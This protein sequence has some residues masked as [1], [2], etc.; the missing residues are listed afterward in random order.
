MTESE[1]LP[2]EKP[3][4]PSQI[5][6]PRSSSQESEEDAKSR[7]S[8]SSSKGGGRSF[9]FIDSSVDRRSSS[10]AVR[11]HVMRESHRTR[12]QLKGMQQASA[13][14]GQMSFLATSPSED[15]S[16][17]APTP[18]TS[19]SRRSSQGERRPSRQ[20]T[21][22]SES[23]RGSPNLTRLVSIAEEHCKVCS[24]RRTFIS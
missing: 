5:T 6:F 17:A 3:R 1:Q 10:E 16:L 21:P 12:R 2:A 23:G 15:T 18:R 9:M 13:P 22:V 19:Q 14:Q 4:R 24:Y 7:Q 8:S 11:V 20:I